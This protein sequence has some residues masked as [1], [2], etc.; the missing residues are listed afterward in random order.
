MRQTEALVQEMIDRAD[1]EPLGVI[2]RDGVKSQ[3]GQP[4]KPAG[5]ERAGGRLGA[6][7]PQLPWG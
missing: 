1:A 6:A 5:T 2:G 3:P 7:I 4:P